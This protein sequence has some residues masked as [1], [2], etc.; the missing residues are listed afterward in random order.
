MVNREFPLVVKSVERTAAA[1][2]NV[3]LRLKAHRPTN[4]GETPDLRLLVEHQIIS[5]RL[6]PSLMGQRRTVRQ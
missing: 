1:R 2:R 3:L 6:V 5:S 4:L